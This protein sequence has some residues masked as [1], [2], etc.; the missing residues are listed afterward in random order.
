[1]NK[2]E[3]RSFIRQ[4]SRNIINEALSN[5]PKMPENW[6]GHELRLYLADRFRA[7]VMSNCMQGKRLKEYKNTIIINNL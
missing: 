5:I 4:L 7:A 1:M 6:D 3:K 2:N